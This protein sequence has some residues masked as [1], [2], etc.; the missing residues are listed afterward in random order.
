MNN[1]VEKPE[2]KMAAEMS[3]AVLVITYMNLCS[4][5]S[6]LD[7]VRNVGDGDDLSNT[8]PDIDVTR[9][10]LGELTVGGM[11]IVDETR[12]FSPTVLRLVD[13]SSVDLKVSEVAVGCEPCTCTLR[14]CAFLSCT[15]FITLNKMELKKISSRTLVVPHRNMVTK[16]P[17]LIMS[18][19]SS[20]V[21][22]VN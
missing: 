9:W 4:F 14:I 1:R 10:R 7:E 13:D 22:S 17:S 2:K 3:T 21:I 11:V 18:Q 15:K 6:K 5:A 20:C 8:L 16:L 19:A 12:S